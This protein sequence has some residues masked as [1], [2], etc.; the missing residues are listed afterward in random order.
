LGGEFFNLINSDEVIGPSSVEFVIRFV[1]GKGSAADKF[2]LLVLDV[3]LL[4]FVNNIRDLVSLLDIV[5]EHGDLS[6]FLN[7]PGRG[8]IEDF[9]SFFSTNNNPVEFLR[10]KDA[11][12]WG[13]VIVR[14]EPFSLDKIPDHDL[15]VVRTGSKVR[16]VV[17]HIDGVDLSLVSHEGVHELHVGVIPNLDSLIPGS[18]DADGGLLSVVESDARDGISMGVLVNSVL[19]FSLNIPDFD[20]MITSTSENLSAVS[21]KGNRKDISGVTDEL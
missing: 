16:R 10:E 14:G 3:S 11:V 1:P 9:D 5:L 2:G 13:V 20:L 18:S 15:T 6:D 12:N 17:D 4:S 19:A 8:E 21:R 7:V